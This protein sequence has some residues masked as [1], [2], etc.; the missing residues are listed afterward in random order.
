[1]RFDPTPL[2]G[3]FVIEMERHQD[4]R[5]FFAR[6]YCA[7]EFREQGLH[8]EWPQCNTSYN[9]RAGTLRGM[10]WQAAPH[11]EVKLVRCT[12]G[13]VFDVIVDLRPDSPTHLHP[14][15]VELTA[16]NRKQLYIPKG[17]AHGFITLT[18]DTEVFYHM[19]SSYVPGSAQGAR[20]DDPAFNIEWPRP[21]AVISERDQNYPDYAG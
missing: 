4:E 8:T 2:P 3:A 19:G 14:F 21:I 9:L 7:S 1:M 6:T 10:H 20:Y 17:F 12:A 16:D 15:G 13:A 18:D 5:G 11:A